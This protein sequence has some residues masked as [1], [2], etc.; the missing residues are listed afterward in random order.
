M[1]EVIQQTDLIVVGA[2]PAGLSAANRAAEFGL[3]VTVIDEF[4]EPGGRMLGQFHEEG[5]H[6]W[7]GKKIADELIAEAIGHGVRIHCGVS[8]YGMLQVDGRWEVSTSKGAIFAPRVLL[9]TGAAE[10]P[11]PLPGWTL[12]G[13]M[14]IGAAQVMTNV[15]FVKP[16]RRGLIIGINVLAMAIARELSVSGVSL[17]GIVLPPAGPL[18]GTAAQPK[19]NLR[20]LMGL[21]HLAPSQLLR[22]G[23]KIAVACRLTNLIAK[24]YP[25]KGI[26]M[27]DI[28]LRMRT[29][30]LSIN[31]NERVESVTL[32]HV[33]SQGEIIE[34]S[35]WE[36]KVDFVALAGG[37]YPLAELTSVAGC[38]FIY[39]PELGGHIPLHSE[40]MRTPVKGLYVA[41][42]ITG[43]ESA[44]VAMSQGRLAAA[45]I[46]YDAS[47]LGDDGEL[48]VVEAMEE[49]NHIRTTALIQFH[50]GITE[51]RRTI[52]GM[53]KETFGVGV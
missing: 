19:T 6:W 1:T 40:Q 38:P 37:L 48:K 32:A 33:N 28:P 46:C 18:A 29:A 51:A 47:V 53:W 42:N 24:F 30:A 15:N 44:L 4:P 14:S 5:G 26:R 11:M 27:W 8:V 34:G 36:E 16:G 21:S 7:V 9:A 49:V 52:Y 10:I 23:G 43:V 20:L 31:G 39:T 2:G 41:G 35:Q 22:W 50:P 17:T 25:K 45:S 3:Q 12:P 13:V